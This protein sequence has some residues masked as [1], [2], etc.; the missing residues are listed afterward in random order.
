MGLP[1]E[2]LVIAT[3]ENDILH[4][5][6]STGMYSLSDVVATTSPSMDIQ[7]SSNFERFLFEAAG[8][9]AAFVAG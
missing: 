5:A 6:W 4:R 8:R 3:N 9:D 2:R 7:I 1:A